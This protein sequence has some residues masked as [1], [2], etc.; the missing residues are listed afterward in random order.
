MGR[1]EKEMS[2]LS[3]SC[4]NEVMLYVGLPANRW[5]ES[6]S[7]KALYILQTHQE[8]LGRPLWIID[9]QASTNL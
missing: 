3:A 4:T 7:I 9:K 8:A 6:N 5:G 1:G 2:V